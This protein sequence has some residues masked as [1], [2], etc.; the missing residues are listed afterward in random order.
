MS[1]LD[2]NMIRDILPDAHDE[3]RTTRNWEGIFWRRQRFARAKRPWLLACAGG[4]AV[5]LTAF[6]GWI[7]RA[8]EGPARLTVHGGDAIPEI[9]ADRVLLSDGSRVEI[10]SGGRLELLENGP[11]RIRWWL[12]EGRAEFDV[13]PDGPRRWVIETHLITVEVLGTVFSVE[14]S[15][16]DVRVRVERGIVLVRG[17]RVPEG[18]RRLVRG[19]EITVPIHDDS[20]SVA[21]DDA[22]EQVGSQ[23]D[24]P[25]LDEPSSDAPNGDPTSRQRQSSLEHVERPPTI[26]TPR[27]NLDVPEIEV[28]SVRERF[29]RADTLRAQGRL[30]EAVAL[31]D[32]IANDVGASSERGLAMLTLARIEL[33]PRDRPAIAAN[34]FAR[35]VALGLPAVLEDDARARRV[36]ALARIP[37]L[38]AARAA[39]EEYHRFHPEGR[40]RDEVDRWADLR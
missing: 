36:E 33:D 20:V 17:E 3:A 7:A 35:A 8:P 5:A 37:D 9:I 10:S 23:L 16:H 38:L 25:L 40:W 1:G 2:P 12:R 15:E 22:D 21:H 18:M 39:A 14:E 29:H 31:L 19:D 4:F 6:I 28:V 27:P 30:D 32:A 24:V 34:A 26:E 11:D 13:T